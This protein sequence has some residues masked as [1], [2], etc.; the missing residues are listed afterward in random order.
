MA[1]MAALIF[2][3]IY[4]IVPTL[5]P[6]VQVLY[7]TR[8]T[9]M[10]R[11]VVGVT[12]INTNTTRPTLGNSPRSRDEAH[13]VTVVASVFRPGPDSQRETVE[14]AYLYIDR[15]AEWLRVGTNPTLGLGGNVDGYV[16]DSSLDVQADNDELQAAGRYAAVTAI[17]TVAAYRI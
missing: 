12:A 10:N 2:G 17:L 5:D 7:G 1:G 13:Q 15:L 8:A 9:N 11:D 3:A 6:E 16:S 14:K 4:D